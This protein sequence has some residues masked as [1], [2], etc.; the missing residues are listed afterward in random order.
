MNPPQT[1]RKAIAVMTDLFFA[2]KIND[3][4][5]R[6]GV[7]F[8]MT[9]TLDASLERARA[10]VELMVIDLN[11]QEI[12]TIALIRAVKSDPALAGTRVVAF[13]SHV[14]EDLRRAAVE[15]GADTVMPR[16]RFVTVVDSLFVAP[17]A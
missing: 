14:F 3:A 9:K 5:K 8:T 11:C 15:A 4:A 7:A 17:A 16:S 10:G 13:L 1:N 6:A 2:V 12:D